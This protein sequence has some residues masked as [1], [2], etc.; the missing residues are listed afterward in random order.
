MNLT[1][2]WKADGSVKHRPADWIRQLDT[3]QFIEKLKDNLKYAPEAYM[4]TVMGRYGGTYAHTV[5][6]S[7]LADRSG[8]CAVFES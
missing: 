7:P 2:M 5:T 3:I 4:K 1:N 8:I 6:A